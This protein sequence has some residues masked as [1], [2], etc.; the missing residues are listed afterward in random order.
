MTATARP[1]D[2]AFLKAKVAL[3]ADFDDQRLEELASGS[4]TETYEPGDII[5][6]AGE[7]L[8]FLGVILEGKIAA[9]V[10]NRGWQ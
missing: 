4:R 2:V 8:H 6:Y 5:V 9:S 7:E 3:L 1:E 10:S